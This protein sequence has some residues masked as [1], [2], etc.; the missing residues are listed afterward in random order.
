MNFEY[1]KLD[2]G[3]TIIGEVNP[4]AQSAAVGF[5]VRTGARDETPQISG[6]S[7][8]LEHMLFKGTDALSALEVNAA[9]DRLGAKFNA[10]TSEENTVYYAAVL[11]EYL[12]DVAELWM[13]LMRPSLRD[14]DFDIEKNVILEEIAMYKDLP[15]FEVMDQARAL[16][17]GSHPCG[18]S[19][20]GTN[21][22]V[23]SL[24]AEQMRSYFSKRY[25]PNNMV[26]ACSGNVDFKALCQLAQEQC[27]TW[28]T[29]D[30]TRELKDF[31]GTFEAKHIP[32]P[33][34]SRQHICLLS[35]ALSM[36]DPRR[37]AASLLGTVLGDD[38][39][40]RY[41]WGLTEP[42]LAEIAAM[43]CESMDGTG[44]FFSYFCCDPDR[45]A[46]V[47]DAVQDIFTE[48]EKTPISGAELE[49][50]KNKKLSGLTIGSEQP[51]GRLVTLGFNWIYNCRYQSVQQ[52]MDAIK[53]VRVADISDLVQQ[54]KPAKFTMLSLGPNSG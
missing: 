32:N 33:N 2:N 44:A 29:V 10:F 12:M 18:N 28:D 1:Q 42:A 4:L 9:F 23:S 54:L 19:V 14:D 51:M 25:A 48:I 43:Q 11:P 3:L 45:A 26:L 49:A 16:H 38:S 34:L 22:S 40:S 15:Q 36:Q 27:A 5:F 31:G 39:G 53:A 13:Q 8:Y 6:V 30:T 21:E 41:Y 37:F 20:L 35:P 52:D 47:L 50:A 46:A 24:T 17:F 7:H